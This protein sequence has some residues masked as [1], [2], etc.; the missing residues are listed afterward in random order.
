MDQKFTNLAR[1]FGIAVLAVACAGCC[2]SKDKDYDDVVPPTVEV[3]ETDLNGLVT[4]KSGQPIQNASV[5]VQDITV[6]TDENGFYEIIAIPEGNYKITV[7][8]AG[9]T[10]HNGTV[11]IPPKGT[12]MAVQ[13]NVSLSSQESTAVI[14]VSSGQ[15]SEGL[16]YTEAINFNRV[17]GV[18]EVTAEVDESAIETG[19]AE[20][21]NFYLEPIYDQSE[22]ISGKDDSAAPAS[23]PTK[24]SD[25]EDT[26]L[27]VGLNITCDKDDVKLLKPMIISFKMDT[28]SIQHVDLLRLVNDEWIKHAFTENNGSLVFEVYAMGSYGVFLPFVITATASKQDLSFET[29]VWDNFYG[30]GPIKVSEVS[31][32]YMT[33]TNIDSRAADVLAALLIERLGY[34]YGSTYITQ[35]AYYPLNVTL[36]IG[37]CL[38][39]SG[40]Q[41]IVDIVVS[42]DKWS[43]HGTHYGDVHIYTKAV[44]R[45]H[46]GGSN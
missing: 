7:S 6:R 27:L 4:D 24:A 26:R 2:L 37:T 25:D 18:I 10:P 33:G 21:V 13:Y 11:N 16:S 46:N 3:P 23:V 31:Y 12:T 44:N 32:D 40:Y 9:K 35:T 1:V 42:Y 15:P 38:S 34:F 28:E 39:I 17:F 20:K 30:S 36:P 41:D 29:S 8:S 19:D 43:V 5:K 22:A 45:Q 14:S